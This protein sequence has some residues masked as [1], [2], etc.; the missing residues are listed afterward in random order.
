MTSLNPAR[1][2]G[3]YPKKGIIAVG[4]DADIVIFNSKKKHTILSSNNHTKCDY[5]IYQGL[6][7]TGKC[8]KVI[9]RGKLLIDNGKDNIPKGFGNYLP[10]KIPN[11]IH[12]N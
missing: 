12:L 1:L 9:L 2:F 6:E 7:L 5:S 3:L 8:E 10:R 11:I 4:S